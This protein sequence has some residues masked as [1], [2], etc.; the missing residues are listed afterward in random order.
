MCQVSV[1]SG[2]PSRLLFWCLLGILGLVAASVISVADAICRSLRV[3]TPRL[4]R[5]FDLDFDEFLP[6]ILPRTARGRVGN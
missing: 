2:R 3:R 5:M 1:L 6:G 4:I